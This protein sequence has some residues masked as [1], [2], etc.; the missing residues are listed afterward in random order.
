V[1]EKAYDGSSAGV[2]AQS[3][4]WTVAANDQVPAGQQ[5][6]DVGGTQGGCV[7]LAAGRAA[8]LADDA[9]LG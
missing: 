6:E 2:D 4:L 3:L 9:E 1:T 5:A 8:C 7:D